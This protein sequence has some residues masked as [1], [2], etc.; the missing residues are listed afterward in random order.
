MLLQLHIQNFAIIEEIT[1]DFTGGL[2]VITGETGAGKSIIAGALSL[3]LGERADTSILKRRDQKVVVEASFRA[4]HLKDVEKF[5]TEEELDREQELVLRREIS[6]NGKSRA[7]VNDTPVNLDQLRRLCSMLV[8]LHQQFDILSLGEAGFQL[9]VVDALAANA[10]LLSRYHAIFQQLQQARVQLEQLKGRQ[11]TADR[12]NDYHK[13]LFNELEEAGLKENEFEEAEIL[14]KRQSH[15]EAIKTV[16]TG[17]YFNLMLSEQ[18]LVQQ[19]RLSA[20]QLEPFRAYHEKFPEILQR[21]S[22]VHI[23]MQDLAGEIELVNEDIQYD[24]AMIE[25]LNERIHTGYKLF[26]KHGVTTTAGLIELRNQLQNKL[27]ESLNIAEEI[28]AKE[29]AVESLV[30]DATA[31]A[32]NLSAN[33]KAQLEG[34]EEKVNELL[35]KVGMPNARIRVTGNTA[36]LNEQGMD[37]IEFLFDANKSDRFEPLKKVASGGELSRLMLCIKSLVAQSMDMPTLLFDEIDSGISGEAARQV[38]IILKE[39]SRKRQVI[40]ITHQ[41]Q[42]A[43]KGDAHFYVFKELQG[44]AINTKIRLLDR[45]ERIVTIA[46]MLSGEKPTAA[47]MENARELVN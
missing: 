37:H 3:V 40:C 15:S 17:I 38:G 33:R 6:A 4:F 19:I 30:K 20:Q 9:A 32:Y 28:H 18:P 44:D 35:K 29:K 31:V 1:I 43:G 8:D 12:E 23:E 26:K 10:T 13:F 24:A 22:S 45:E 27:F 36:V 46:K 2:Q 5:L 39:L 11:A 42:I 7:F 25:K 41:P 47:A 34:L 21:L 14:L 16:L